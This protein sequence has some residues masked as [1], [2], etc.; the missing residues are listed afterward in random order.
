MECAY[1]LVTPILR[2][3]S[4]CLLCIFTKSFISDV[5]LG[6]EYTWKYFFVKPVYIGIRIYRPNHSF[7]HCV[8]YG[9][10]RVSLT[11]VL[12][13]FDAVKVLS[14]C[15]NFY[16]WYSFKK[17][18]SSHYCT[19]CVA[20]TANNEFLLKLFSNSFFKTPLKLLWLS[21]F[22]WSTGIRPNGEL[23]SQKKNEHYKF[24]RTIS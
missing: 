2:N 12:V 24:W 6:S 18:T 9:R 14:V 17:Y 5:W 20:D 22:T 10:I 23:K 19:H 11:H 1:S 15:W 13:Y 16:L 7:K 4:G 21:C 3:C 8:K